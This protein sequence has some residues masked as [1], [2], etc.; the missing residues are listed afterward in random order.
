VTEFTLSTPSSLLEIY[1]KI[2]R[3]KEMVMKVNTVISLFIYLLI[4]TGV[5]T[6]SFTPANRALSIQPSFQPFFALVI[7]RWGLGFC[8]G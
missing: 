3:H 2:F 7:L 1:K 6:H 8:L 4:G 5:L